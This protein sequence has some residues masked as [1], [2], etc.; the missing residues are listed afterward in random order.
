MIE[1]DSAYTAGLAALFWPMMA[2][3]RLVNTTPALEGFRIT[4]IFVA[5]V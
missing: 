4:L 3:E 1:P 5:Q 2:Y